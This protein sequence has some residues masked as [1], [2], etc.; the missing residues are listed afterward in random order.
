MTVGSHTDELVRWGRPARMDRTDDRLLGR[1][2]ESRR[3][4][5]LLGDPDGPRLVLVRGEHGVGRSAFL[6]TAGER[7]RA[8][9]GAVYAVDCVPGDADRPLLLA[10]RLVMTLR[11]RRPAVDRGDRAATEVLSAVD[12]GDLASTEALMRA[13]LARCAPMTVL[14]DDAQYADRGSL[15][16][17]SR[18][19]VPGVRLVVSVACRDGA[20]PDTPAPADGDAPH[21]VLDTPSADAVVLG[22]LGPHDTD[23]L[24]AR[25]LQAEADTQLAR[26]IRELTHGLPGAVE[27]LLT[28]WTRQDVIR[29]ADGHA[30]VPSRA[31]VPV[32]PD[33][34]RFLTALDRLGEPARTVAAALS[35]LGPL[36]EPALQL[37]AQCTGLSTEAVHESA[38]RLAEAGIVD[39]APG[40]PYRLPL[41][42]HAV[43]ER[44]SPVRRSRLSAAAVEA[45]WTDAGS[46]RGGTSAPPA[47]PGHPDGTAP[48]P[49]LLRSDAGS[50]RGGTS[51]PPAEPGH[52]GGTAP[53]PGLLRSDAGSARGGTSAQHAEPGHPDGTAP[54]PGLLRSDAGSAPGDTSAPHAD[55]G[56]LD[57]AGA[58]L[59]GT[60]TPAYR[61]DRIADAGSLVDRERAVAELTDA[62][63]QIRPGIDDGRV[64]RWLRAAR[65]LTEH[66]DARDLV[67]QQYGTTAYLACDYAAARAAAESLLR[68]P[69]PTLSDLDL[70]EAACLIVAVTANQRDWPTMSRL[71]TAHWWDVL[72]V[73]ALARVTGRALALCHL[74]RWR[75][76]ED[77]LR[78]TEAVWNTGP[79]ARAA[80]AVFLAMAELGLGRPEPYRR[81]LSFDE[82]PQLPPGKVYSLAGGMV[83][84]LL[85]RYD[86]A[87]ATALLATTGLT[88]PVLPPLSRFLH[89]HLTGDWDQALESARRLLAGREIQSTPVADSSLLPAR[90]AAILLAQGRVTTALQLVRDADGEGAPPQCSLHATEA[91]LLMALGDLTGAERTLRTGLDRTR[92]H[93]QTYGTDELW[94]LLA[95]LTSQAGRDREAAECVRHLADLVHRTGTD[96]TRLLHLLASA[97]V[98]RDEAPGTAH[99]ALREAVDLARERGLPFE[100][101]TTLVTAATA[102]AVPA[103]L[104]HEAYEVFGRTGAA[105]WRFRTRTA[106][107]EAG[108]TV[109][110]RSR[111]TAEND[112]LLTTLLT[113]QL[114]TRQIA[115]VLHL[116]EDAVSRRLSRL[117]ARTG[118]RSRT[119]LVT[120]SLTPTF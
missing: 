91:E 116:T 58:L 42:A 27:A 41:T 88:V 13:V 8:S 29:V 71:G 80:P 63:R 35:I 32:L 70:Q 82:A 113:E 66:A 54:E 103:A 16:A 61:A 24:V 62:A 94:A 48:E 23:A 107:R 50:A 7:L 39:E 73:P 76:T 95:Q 36:G 78:T 14:V 59:G 30:F 28:A 19:D 79:R 25:W 51:A 98:Q 18:I 33:D 86:L 83:D 110:G 93:D 102:G 10:L 69:G 26:Q 43:R 1:E 11:E 92:A 56:P 104:L 47:E 96:R 67:L 105:L 117:F 53:E 12:R 4:D 15:S 52:P 55:P 97:R 74:S 64:L 120:A 65:D 87:G 119:E 111:A 20:G 85:T 75:Q 44:L 118:K 72:P 5:G 37:T 17:L 115:R 114:T 90:T 34:D 21:H 89:H 112:G 49:G 109:P 38:R 68:D 6:R 106:L 108:L 99:R 100:T 9:G 40:L 60:D 46:A 3:L 101:A 45:L 57:A 22:P 31:T 81:A 77:L 2:R 84:N